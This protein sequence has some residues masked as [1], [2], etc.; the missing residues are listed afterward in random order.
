MSGMVDAFVRHG[1]ET[2]F[3][4]L[5]TDAV[6]AIKTYMLD[7]LGVGI[8]GAA[9]PLAETVRKTARGW[10]ADGAAH[11]WGAGGF[12]TTPANAAFINGFQIH[13][14]EYDC[15]H[16]PA[17]VHPL[18][19]ILAAL[20]AEA[21]SQGGVTGQEFAVALAVAVDLAAGIGVSV[22]SP[23]KFFRPANAGI[24]GAT[25]GISRLR[26]LSAEKAKDAL[27]YALAFNSGTMQAHVEGKPALPIQIGNAARGAVMACDLAAQGMPGPHDSLEGPFGYFSLFEDE[28]DPA[29]VMASLGRIWRI[30]EVSHKPFPTGRAAQGGIVLIQK[31][32]AAGVEPDNVE[33][34]TLTAPPLIHR[35]VGR[36]IQHDMAVNYARLCFQYS[37]A[38][39]LK[40][41]TVGLED[42]SESALADP[43]TLALG[44]RIQVI[45]D[46]GSNPAAFTP[47]IAVAT[48]KDGREVREE[49]NSLY[50]SPSDPM[51][52]DAHLAKFR[53]CI[54]FGF[55]EQRP[56][57][58]HKLIELTDQL[59][60][61]QDVSVLSRLAAGLEA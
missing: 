13:G 40:T 7:T 12:T 41:G 17:V 34:I 6:T 35:L 28:A 43:E 32:K 56:Q 11:V 55:G 14:Q 30:A 57:I 49:I 50:G 5:S 60:E 21:D 27:G 15:V 23:I 16:E 45:D 39:A 53:S 3:A 46:G 61:V 22:S 47:Q 38:V 52:R 1:L 36:P 19:T 29:D 8:A 2:E 9:I 42:F 44:E 18:A 20:M 10:G 37:G 4:D 51:P 48:L 59:E 25:L 54:T 24:F 26:K 33:Q 58:E 31:L